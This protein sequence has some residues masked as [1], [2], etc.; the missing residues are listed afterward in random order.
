MARRNSKSAAGQS[1]PAAVVPDARQRVL[2]R[3]MRTPLRAGS[4]GNEV[5]QHTGQTVHIEAR[6]PVRDCAHGVTCWYDPTTWLAS[7]VVAVIA[8]IRPTPVTEWRL[9][10]VARTSIIGR[11]R[12]ASHCSPPRSAVLPLEDLKDLAAADLLK[13]SPRGPRQ[14]GFRRKR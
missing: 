4:G 6:V 14:A 5:A 2:L 3:F 11:I 13:H 9:H 1:G 12:R 8:A 10:Q 7:R